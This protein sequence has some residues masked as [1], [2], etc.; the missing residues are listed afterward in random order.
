MDHH[1]A[2]DGEAEAAD[3]LGVDVGAA[4]Q[5]VGGGVEI[6]LAVPAEE[7]RVAFAG[8][9]AAPVEEEDAVA[10]ADEHARLPLRPR[11]PREGDD[12]GAVPRGHEPA[13]E[14]QAVA[15]REGDV[16]VGG[17]EVRSR[18]LRAGGVR[19]DVGDGSREQHL[20][21]EDEHADRDRGA[22]EVAPQPAVVGAARAPERS[23][24]DAEQEEAGGDRQEPGEV[25]AGRAALK[26]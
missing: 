25:V 13:L 3:L 24:A 21:D 15:R 6:P 16:L 23:H 26:E 4:A 8:A 10:V 2:A 18:H 17:A 1:L 20:R 14:A 5:V 22:P 12:S 9:L 7:V 11:A 19:D